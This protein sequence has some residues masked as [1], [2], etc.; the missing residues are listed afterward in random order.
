MVRA[1]QPGL[2][3]LSMTLAAVAG[4]GAITSVLGPDLVRDVGLVLVFSLWAAWWIWLLVLFLRN[5]DPLP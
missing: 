5:D 3:R 2:A 4:I 1:D